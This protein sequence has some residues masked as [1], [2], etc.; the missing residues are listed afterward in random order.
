MNGNGISWPIVGAYALGII[1]IAGGAVVA[2]FVQ[3]EAGALLVAA[4]GWW[5][6]KLQTQPL[7]ASSAA[8][9]ALPAAE[10]GTPEGFQTSRD[11]TRPAEPSAPH[12]KE[13]KG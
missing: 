1:A 8:K 3:Q 13:Q 11:D 9:G 2:R 5:L 6:G 10:I 7:F 4:G 12:A